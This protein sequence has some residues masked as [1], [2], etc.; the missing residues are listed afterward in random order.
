MG[1][2]SVTFTGASM[3]EVARL[4]AAWTPPLAPAD[5]GSAASTSTTA[6]SDLELIGRV[7]ANVR[8][9][10]TRRLLRVIAEAGLKGETVTLSEALMSDFGVT[11]GSAFAG[12]VAQANRRGKT[13]MGRPLI[14][15]PSTDLRAKVWQITPEDAK[16]V[17]KA[18]DG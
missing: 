14:G 9:T 3:A 13:I 1:S 15:H 17:L 8:G 6:A 16:A 4:I 18:L 11:S 5:S 10:Q 2:I 7:L 12:M